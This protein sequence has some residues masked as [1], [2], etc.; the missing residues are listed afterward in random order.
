LK[1]S[2]FMGEQSPPTCLLKM[3]LVPPSSPIPHIIVLPP[4]ESHDYEKL[5]RS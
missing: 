3:Y 2:F 5:T 1:V 4:A